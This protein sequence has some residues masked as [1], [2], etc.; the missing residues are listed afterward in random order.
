MYRPKEDTEKANGFSYVHINGR[1]IVDFGTTVEQ[2]MIQTDDGL[3]ARSEHG[4]E[5]DVDEQ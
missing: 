5:T 3:E 4:S 2:Y 1:L